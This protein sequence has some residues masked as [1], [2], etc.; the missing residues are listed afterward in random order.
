MT[1][2]ST[3][4]P[5]TASS[6]EPLAYLQQFRLVVCK[7]CRFACVA[8]EVATH[9]RTRHKDLS[10]AVRRRIAEA[11]AQLPSV[12]RTQAQLTGLQLPRPNSLPVPLIHPPKS[13]GLRCLECSYIA[14]Q[15]KRM[16]E[17]LRKA[18]GW[19]NPQGTGRPSVRIRGTGGRSGGSCSGD[20]GDREQPWVEGV[21]CQRFFL[22]RAGSS[23]FELNLVVA[24]EEAIIAGETTDRVADHLPSGP[25]PSSP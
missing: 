10:P 8:D 11:S 6:L 4:T 15:T 9:L 19:R 5:P 7:E 22:S 23:W 20:E 14:R 13:D 1:T 12:I 17:H 18:H 2:L 16:K 25:S 3:P 21:H 24:Q